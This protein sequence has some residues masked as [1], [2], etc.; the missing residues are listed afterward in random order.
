MQSLI[1]DIQIQF[2]S[3]KKELKGVERGRERDHRNHQVPILRD[4]DKRI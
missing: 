3:E 2:L 1:N 4:L